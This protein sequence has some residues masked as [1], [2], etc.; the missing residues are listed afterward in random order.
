MAFRLKEQ[1]LEIIVQYMEEHPDFATG[2]LCVANSKEKFKCMWQELTSKLNSL[3]YG[4]RP[5]E[6]WQKVN[7]KH[8]SKNF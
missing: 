5:V 7:F 4:I 6:K 1:H 3:G 2:R 8:V